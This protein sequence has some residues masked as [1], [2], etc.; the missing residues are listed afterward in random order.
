MR[1]KIGVLGL[2]GAIR[3]H[4]W[5]LEKTG[6]EVTVVKTVEHL[7]GLDGLVL[8]GGESTTMRRLL[9]KYELFE[10]VKAFAQQHP[11]FGTCA[12][13]ILMAQ[14]IEGQKGPHLGLM[15]IDVRRNAFGRQVAS[16]EA[17]LAIQHVTEAEDF[18]GVFIRA[19]YI[20]SVGPEVEV[21]ATY[22]DKIV[23]AR[24]GPFLTCAFHPELTEDYRMH[25]YFYEMVKD[26]K[27]KQ[28]VAKA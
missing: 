26:Y 19:P 11:V 12:G 18:I 15:D 4:I 23:A 5:A 6:A 7:E 22:A 3:E 14:H 10:P 9:D 20:L 13:L 21:L 16:F 2:Q 27:E 28:S 25:Q 17:E 8:P 24:Q 1:I